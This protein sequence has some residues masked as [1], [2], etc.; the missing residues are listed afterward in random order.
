LQNKQNESSI[1]QS[2]LSIVEKE[3]PENVGK[4]IKLV[5]IRLNVSEQEILKRVLYLQDQGKLTFEEPLVSL[6]QMFR[7][8]IFSDKAYW[9]WITIV[10]SFSATLSTF[11]IPENA[12]PEVYTRYVLGTIFIWFLP[13]Y[14]FVKALFPA[15]V[16]VP[17]KS[18]ELDLIERVALGIG[19]SIVLVILNGFVLNY[20]SFGIRTTSATL[21]LLAL[22]IAFAVV[23]IF[24]E[25]QAVKGQ[26]QERVNQ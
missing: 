20:T 4:L 14:S 17:T 1:D 13:G 7:K 6:P 26:N 25:F 8:Y 11:T 24:R 19:M 23:G 9:Y 15:T 21:S 10:L 2:I 18:T 5:K 22:T 12:Y 3:N 16:P